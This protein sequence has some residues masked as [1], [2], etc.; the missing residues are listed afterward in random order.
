MASLDPLLQ[1]TPPA[2][3]TGGAAPA[4]SGAPVKICLLVVFNH[5]F[6]ANLPKLDWMYRPR[7]EH[8]RYLVPFYRGDRPDVIPVY[9]SSFQFHGFF[10]EAWKRLKDEGFT[11]YL[12][13]ADDMVLNPRFND[14]NILEVLG[15]GTDSGYIKELLPLDHRELEWSATASA[16]VAVAGK[17]GT[18]WEGELPPA[19]V[20]EENL[21]A[22]GIKLGKFGLHNLRRGIHFKGFFQILFYFILRLLKRRRDPATE[23]LRPPYPLLS[24]IADMM[25]IPAAYMEKFCHY[26][27]VFAAMDVFVEVGAP[28]AL[29]LACPRVVVSWDTAYVAKD[30]LQV[31]G[32]E[33]LDHYCRQYDYRLDV[34]LERFD[35]KAICLHPIKFSRWSYPGASA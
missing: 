27:S 13:C 14:K 5:R 29:A 34:L 31:Y 23:L 7:Y 30:Y 8:V 16:L 35:E 28:T 2:P 6:D 19:A 18:N 25:V 21:R 22:K 26:C 32:P 1:P 11:H 17:N 3:K 9:Y 4:G 33:W 10:M 15:I 12:V 20:A 24:S